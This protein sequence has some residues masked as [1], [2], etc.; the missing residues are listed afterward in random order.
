[1]GSRNEGM[2]DENKAKI[3]IT[4]SRDIDEYRGVKSEIS[5]CL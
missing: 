1:M 2:I 4:G 5:G 3:E